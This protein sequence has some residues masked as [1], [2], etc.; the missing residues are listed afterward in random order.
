M[1]TSPV[2][3]VWTQTGW[4]K[5]RTKRVTRRMQRWLESTGSTPTL[6]SSTFPSRGLFCGAWNRLRPPAPATWR[7]P[8]PGLWSTAGARLQ[9]RTTPRRVALA[10]SAHRMDLSLPMPISPRQWQLRPNMLVYEWQSILGKATISFQCLEVLG[11]VY[12]FL[13]NVPNVI[14]HN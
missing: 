10:P 14:V 9:R 6:T 5:K 8:S 7:A 13:I 1:A 12:A 2:P 3:W 4:R 11:R